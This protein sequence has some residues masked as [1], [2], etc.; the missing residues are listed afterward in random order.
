MPRIK[1]VLVDDHDV[2]R[3]GLKMVLELD[4]EIQVVGE[5]ADGVQSVQCA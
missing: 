3:E 5:A 4:E 2:V 1:V